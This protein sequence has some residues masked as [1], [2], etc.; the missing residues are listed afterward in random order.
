MEM[1][2][3]V[4]A[5]FAGFPPETQTG[6]RALRA[7]ILSV[8]ADTPEAGRLSEE[9][10]WGQ[11]AY[12][13]P[14]TGAGTTLRLGVAKS[15]GFALFVHCQTSLI[16]EFRELAGSDWPVEGRR[17]ILFD[18]TGVTDAIMDPAL[19]LLIRRALTYHL[20]RRAAG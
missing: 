9:L 5:A 2:A 13:T 19:R 20:K 6:L 14:E 3:P 12:L 16:D 11:P 17:A 7:L 8:A 18:E 1:S 4:A 10:R 15:G